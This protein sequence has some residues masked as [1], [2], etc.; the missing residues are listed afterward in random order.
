MLKLIF[1][2]RNLISWMILAAGVLLTVLVAQAT[3]RQIQGTALQQFNV[4]V[5]DVMSSIQS[6]MRQQEQILLGGAGLFDA[7]KSVSRD[8]WHAYVTRLDLDKNYPGI[9]G[10]GYSQ[11]I[12][13]QDLS[14]HIKRIRTEGF[15]QYTVRPPGERPIY[16]SII[17]LE[18]FSGRNLAAFGY[19]MMSEATRAKAMRLAVETGM[20]T[21]SG[22]VTLV[23]ETHGKVQ[24]GFLM[25]VPIFA[26][27]LPPTAAQQKWQAIKGFVY[28]PFRMDDLMQGM[29]FLRGSPIDFSIFDG[30]SADSDS[31][32]Y[33]SREDAAGQPRQAE[34]NEL[35]RIELYGHSWTVSLHSSSNFEADYKSSL[36]STILWMGSGISLLLF[37]LVSLQ[38][39]HREQAEQLAQDITVD[40]RLQRNELQENEQRFRYMLET[41]PTAARISRRGNVLFF[42]TR[43]LKL[44]DTTPENAYGM[45][46]ASYYVDPDIYAGIVRRLDNGEQVFDQLVELHKPGDPETV[47]KWALASFLIIQ[48][49]GKP[50]VLGWFHDITERIRIDKMKSEFIST[51]SHELRTPLTS[52]VGSLGL[53]AGGALGE[54]PAQ[55]KNMIEIAHRNSL[56]LSLLINDLLDME[57]L[58][59]GKMEFKMQLQKLMPLI[60]QALE[61]NQGYGNARNVRLELTGRS[62]DAMVNVDAH[63]LMQVLSNLLSN[64]IKYSPDNGT[65]EVAVQNDQQKVRITVTDRGPGIPAEF[66]SWMFQKFSQADSSDTRQKGG[67]GLGLAI[68]RELVERM[69]GE[70]GFDSVEGQGASF[71]VEFPVA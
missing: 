54:L 28:S 59:E 19:D 11:I 12:Q 68:A 15:P 50:A 38:I 24:A 3:Q 14:S 31:R 71:Y 55:A 18:P 30:D 48:Y 64:A 9:L 49:Q 58:A 4:R 29:M 39:F 41:C 37:F 17:Y 40:L 1:N 52:I 8:A 70:I 32:M 27:G 65:V 26:K 61:D 47:T 53:I 10:V 25:Y 69:G 35:R 43:Y 5:D 21:I 20:T 13:P 16:T 33:D 67:T 42:N 62:Y 23:Q 66:R 57:K 46:P 7:S 56:R 60:K 36:G 44:T 2:R 45:D 6:R 34:F 51:V 22:K 63:R